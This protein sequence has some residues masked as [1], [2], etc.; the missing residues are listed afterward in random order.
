MEIYKILLKEVTLPYRKAVKMGYVK[1]ETMFRCEQ[2]YGKSKMGKVYWDEE[3]RKILSYV[4]EQRSKGVNMVV[5]VHGKDH[6]HPDYVC[7]RIYVKV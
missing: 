2:N 4:N 5:V 1:T 3:R 7:S 6:P